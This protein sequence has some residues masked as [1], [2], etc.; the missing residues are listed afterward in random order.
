MPESSLTWIARTQ[1]TADTSSS[2]LDLFAIDWGKLRYTMAMMRGRLKG[3][4]QWQHST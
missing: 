3:R 2:T 4:R 1:Q